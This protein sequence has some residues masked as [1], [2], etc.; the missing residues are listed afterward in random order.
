VC[1]TTLAIAALLVV[2]S[3]WSQAQQAAI[4]QGTYM[5]APKALA[6]TADGYVTAAQVGAS[7]STVTT[8]G[9][10]TGLAANASLVRMNNA[11]AA[12]IHGIA[13][14]YDGQRLQIVS[15]G[16]GEVDLAHQSSTDGTAAN[17]LI[18]FV[19]SGITPLAP[20]SGKADLVYDGTTARWRLVGHEQGAWIAQT[21]AAG[22][23]TGNNA[24]T[25]T[26]ASGDVTMRSYMLRGRT[27][28]DAYR[29]LTSTVGGTPST[30]L[31]LAPPNGYTLPATFVARDTVII[32]DNGSQS[33]GRMIATGANDRISVSATLAGAAWSAAT[34]T[35]SVE[36]TA[37][38]EVD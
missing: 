11:T 32:S 25:W 23:Y 3:N 10:I 18:N 14:G 33:V 35:T 26:V 21:F 16:A 1:A 29:I 6:V 30:L 4:L 31:L 38:Y 36:G 24:M 13:A 20:G 12:V 9:S 7:V 27:V 2:S 34:D 15:V 28:T 5:G 22:D 8:T 17:R 19:T 37:I